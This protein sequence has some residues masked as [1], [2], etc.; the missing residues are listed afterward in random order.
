MP[1]F[2]QVINILWPACAGMATAVQFFVIDS[3]CCKLA[4]SFL[5]ACC[6]RRMGWLGLGGAVVS[7]FDRFLFE[8]VGFQFGGVEFDRA[9]LRFEPNLDVEV[10]AFDDGGVFE[11]LGLEVA[12]AHDFRQSFAEGA[13]VHGVIAAEEFEVFALFGAE[14]VASAF[15]QELVLQADG[16]VAEPG[17]GGHAGD[18]VALGGV[19]GFP[20]GF[21]V[22]QKGFVGGFAFAGEKLDGFG[23]V[24]GEAVD[25]VVAGGDGEAF[26]GGGAAGELGVGSVGSELASE[27]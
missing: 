19:G 2:A 4:C 15:Q 17:V 20:V 13:A 25:G 8:A 16:A 22:G 9:F 14:F 27:I 5:R 24:R 12:E 26:G 23:G 7:L 10:A 21:E 1:L 18:D 6:F 11:L 3:V